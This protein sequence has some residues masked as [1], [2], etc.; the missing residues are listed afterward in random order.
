MV[1]R[2]PG[3]ECQKRTANTNASNIQAPGDP[4]TPGLYSAIGRR[5]ETTM[6]Q[7]HV[8]TVARLLADGY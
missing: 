1:L 5:R 4:E 8:I 7:S 2:Y 3:A 6:I